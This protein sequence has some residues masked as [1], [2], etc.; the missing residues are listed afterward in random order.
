ML[1]KYCENKVL[2]KNKTQSP[3]AKTDCPIDIN[4]LILEENKEEE[5]HH[6][7][8]KLICKSDLIDFN[9]NSLSNEYEQKMN[10]KELDERAFIKQENF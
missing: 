7:F 8:L 3:R 10:H 6:D 4:T 1:D 5:T 9:F 2:H